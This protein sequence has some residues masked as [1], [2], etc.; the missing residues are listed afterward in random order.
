MLCVSF[1]FLSSQAGAVFVSGG[2]ASFQKCSL[3][4]NTAKLS[5]SSLHL[6]SLI[7]PFVIF[8]CFCFCVHPRP[9]PHSEQNKLTLNSLNIF[10]VFMLF[11]FVVIYFF[12]FFLLC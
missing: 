2:S 10:F 8:L 4:G 7:D 9:P 5:V 6:N 1:L 12:I 11:F 3:S